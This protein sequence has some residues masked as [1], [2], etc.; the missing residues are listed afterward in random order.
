MTLSG[1][2]SILEFDPQKRPRLVSKFPLTGSNLAQLLEQDAPQVPAHSSQVVGD[3][4]GRHPEL[5]RDLIVS[6]PLF[7][8]A[9]IVALEYT[10]LDHLAVRFAALPQSADRQFEQAPN[11]LLMKAV[12]HGR[13][14][15]GQLPLG[16][17]EIERNDSNSAA[18]FQ[19]L[20]G[21]PL[22]GGKPVQARAQISAK[23]RL[24]RI[25]LTKE[26][27]IKRAREEALYQILG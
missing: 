23:T 15:T 16:R 19:S 1:S 9:K 24:R 7:P 17:L 2:Q 8:R 25:V 3:S 14:G 21:L 27:L 22:V 20:G 26:S 12:L 4:G 11:P 18:A 6:D 5:P 13:R 10:K